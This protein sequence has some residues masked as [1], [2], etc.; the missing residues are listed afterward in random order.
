M[1]EALGISR[2]ERSMATLSVAEGPR[3][4]VITNQAAIPDGFWRRSVDKTEI[5]KQL[6]AGSH[7]DGAELANGQP[8]LRIH[9]R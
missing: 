5:A 9:S 4:V 3:A 2:L 8:V 7:V 6:K 1:L